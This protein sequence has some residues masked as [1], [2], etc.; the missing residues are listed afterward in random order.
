MEELT[1]DEVYELVTT[2]T[3][4]TWAEAKA[5]LREG[6]YV[7]L[8]EWLGYWYQE[9]ESKP[10]MAFTRTGDKVP[11]WVDDYTK[12]DD[13][14]MVYADKKLSFSWALCALKAGKKVR[15]T[16]WA[17][18]GKYLWVLPSARIP[19]EWI[20]DEHLK[21][22]AVADGGAVNC[23]GSIRMYKPSK[24]NS[25]SFV[26]TGW[27]PQQDDMFADNW[28]LAEELKH[29]YMSAPNSKVEE[30]IYEA[31]QYEVDDIW[32]ISSEEYVEPESPGIYVVGREPH[33]PPGI[34][35]HVH[36]AR[37]TCKPIE[38]QE[39][40]S[41]LVIGMFRNIEH[42]AVQRKKLEES[43]AASMAIM[44]GSIRKS[45]DTK[46]KKPKYKNR[47]KPWRRTF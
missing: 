12:R 44:S 33:I 34:L 2:K 24:N 13:W 42:E 5:M 20:K 41:N 31:I 43:F 21:S 36:M 4:F 17:G 18:R 11:A 7:R 45:Y 1:R 14:E 47:K 40:V 22:L 29:K 25:V 23:D 8:P 30:Q 35:G 28:E 10:V 27:V 6:Y 46:G 26:M 32:G 16:C 19:V 39:D 15:R 37:S 3:K 9:Y 38:T